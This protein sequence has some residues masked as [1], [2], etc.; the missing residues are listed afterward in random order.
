MNVQIAPFIVCLYQLTRT[1]RGD[2][3]LNALQISSKIDCSYAIVT[4]TYPPDLSRCELLAESLDR[5]APD[6]PH[7]LIVDR[8]D[9]SAFKHLQKGKRR[10]VDYEAVLGNSVWRLPRR[11]GYWFSIKALP[12]RGWIMQQIIKIAAIDVLTE[13]T[14]IFCDSDVAFFRRF[15]RSG[16][17]INGKVGLLDVNYQNDSVRR[18]ATTARRLLGLPAVQ[19]EVR[20]YVGYMVCWNR[21]TVHLMRESISKV[22]GIDWKVALARTLSFSEYMIY[23]TYVREA[24]GY[25]ATDHEPSTVPLVKATWGR[26]LMNEPSMRAFF[27]DF[28]PETIAVMIHS[29]DGILPDYYRPHLEQLWAKL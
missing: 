12:V 2:S 17:L 27:T 4:P 8:R 9:V 23:G 20:N 11:N 13:R 6:V 26:G 21:E 15:D 22:T 10:L 3:K 14:L 28:D 25:A 7:Y 18:W 16:L 24:L 29:K 5:C 19:T 1:P